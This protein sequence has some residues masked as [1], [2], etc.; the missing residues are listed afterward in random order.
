MN[1]LYG[2]A[3]ARD[4]ADIDAALRSG[5]C[6]SSEIRLHLGRTGIGSKRVRDLGVV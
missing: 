1:A 4:F 5:R 3:P 6:S 2:R